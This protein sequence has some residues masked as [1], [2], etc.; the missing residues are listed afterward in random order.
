LS[1]FIQKVDYSMP[2][3]CGIF[4]PPPYEYKKARAL[5]IILQ[6]DFETKKRFLPSTLEPI[7]GGIDGLF[8]SEYPYTTIGPY[9]EMILSLNCKYKDQ[10]GDF[11]CNIYVDDDIALTAGREIW[12]FP[13]KM[14]K[15]SLSPI[16]EN[17]ITG[18]LTR[19]GIKFIDVEAS[20]TDPPK[21]MEPKTLLE[22]MPIYNLKLIPDV[23]DNSKH[24]IRQITE[25]RPIYGEFYDIQGIKVNYLNTEYS[26]YDICHEILEN[27]KK[28]IGGFYLVFDL[29]L[30]NGKI[31]E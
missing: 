5:A 17:K 2:R 3:Q 15:I 27:A 18:S 13:K 8:I 6:C 16:K 30:P 7:K 22:S 19:K 12:G 14:C 10:P 29:I 1:E 9:N 31:L 26:Q 25:T 28:N 20:L 4:P 24:A 11:I 23:A 21:G